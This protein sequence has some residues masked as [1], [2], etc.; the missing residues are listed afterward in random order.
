MM[1]NAHMKPKSAVPLK[2]TAA[3]TKENRKPTKKSAAY[4]A[5][6]SE[7]IAVLLHAKDLADSSLM[8]EFALKL[9]RNA[10][11]KLYCKPSREKWLNTPEEGN[12]E[13]Q[14]YKGYLAMTDPET[15]RGE[16][17]EG[18][19]IFEVALTRDEYV[20]LKDHLAFFRRIRPYEPYEKH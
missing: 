8:A 16:T 2:I 20:E 17:R 11:S 18:L 6:E 3:S 12:A 4:R 19:G 14:F 13:G 5:A 7:L 9:H 1:Y 10:L 15:V